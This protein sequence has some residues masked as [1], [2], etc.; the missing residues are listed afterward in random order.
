MAYSRTHELIDFVTSSFFQTSA[1]SGQKRSLCRPILSETC[2][3]ARNDGDT[4]HNSGVQQASSMK[5]CSVNGY[6]QQRKH[7]G[8]LSQYSTK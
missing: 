1:L 7:S 2:S 6:Y 8:T 5:T 3:F 4:T